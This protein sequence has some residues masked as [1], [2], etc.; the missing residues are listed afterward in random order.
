MNIKKNRNDY[1]L[2]TGGFFNLELLPQRVNLARLLDFCLDRAMCDIVI[3][4][5]IG[6]PESENKDMSSIHLSM[7]ATALDATITVLDNAL[8]LTQS[9]AVL[10][11][12]HSNPF[13]TLA[14]TG[15][16]C[17]T[18]TPDTLSLRID[19]EDGAPQ[20][21]NNATE[22]LSYLHQALRQSS[23]MRLASDNAKNLVHEYDK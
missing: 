1:T 3:A 16:I 17:L 18:I 21:I 10:D 13:M 6:S 15:Q 20:P 5:T 19:N 22:L 7:F 2:S 11:L 9:I 12:E 23:A 4:R 14:V 8:V